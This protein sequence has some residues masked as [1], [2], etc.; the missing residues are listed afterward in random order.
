MTNRKLVVVVDDDASML[1]AIERALKI[2]G[3][4]CVTFDNVDDFRTNA[5]LD[6]AACVVLDINLAG[7]SGIELRK[8]LA[9][10]GRSV[11]VV[12]ITGADSVGARSAALKAGCVG[13]LTKP[14]ASALLIEAIEKSV[15]QGRRLT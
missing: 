8:E 5:N 9:R 2:H 11:P 13:Y 7:A 6:E 15:K 10:A 14:F 3:F 12:F 1:R 4:D